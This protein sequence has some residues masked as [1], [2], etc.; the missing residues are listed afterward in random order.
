MNIKTTQTDAFL[1]RLRQEFPKAE[2]V[3]EP[4]ACEDDPS[5]TLFV[6]VLG[7]PVGALSKASRR[8]WSLAFEVFGDHPIPFLLTT[9]DPET[10]ATHFPDAWP[11]S[12]APNA[13]LWFSSSAAG[14]FRSALPSIPKDAKVWEAFTAHFVA[15][16]DFAKIRSAWTSMEVDFAI[17][18]TGETESPTPRFFDL[19]RG[20]EVLIDDV[21]IEAKSVSFE[22]PDSTTVVIEPRKPSPS[23]AATRVDPINA[24]YSNYSLAA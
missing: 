9:V 5:I 6:H 4:H 18:R 22:P 12:G 15:I 8:C 1:E 23:D 2:I 3:V 7:I 14:W 17:G 19:N 16:R 24:V 11:P 13:E 21:V 20:A 10:A